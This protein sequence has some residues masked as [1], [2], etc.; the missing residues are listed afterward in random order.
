MEVFLIVLLIVLFNALLAGFYLL[1][2]NERVGVFRIMLNHLTSGLLINYINSFE[3]DEEF[4]QH[5][6][7]YKCL[8]RASEHLQNKYT[9]S[10]MLFSFKPLRLESWFTED[11]LFFLKAYKQFIPNEQTLKCEVKK[12]LKDD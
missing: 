9:Y 7:E 4:T 12:A 5:Y 2:R 3:N 6:S 1:I 10:Q 11:E 8:N